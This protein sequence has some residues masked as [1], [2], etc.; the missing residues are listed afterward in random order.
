MG[1]AADAASTVRAVARRY[2]RTSP[3]LAV[4]RSG[5]SAARNTSVVR[6]SA[7]ARLPTRANSVRYTQVALSWYTASQLV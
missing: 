1:G 3:T 7:S 6:S 4:R 2:A 5:R